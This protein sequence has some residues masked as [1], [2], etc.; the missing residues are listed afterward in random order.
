MSVEIPSAR[1]DNELGN[2]FQR[3]V[4]LL[5]HQ[6]GLAVIWRDQAAH[7][8]L[9]AARRSHSQFST[10]TRWNDRRCT[11]MKCSLCLQWQLSHSGTG[12]SMKEGE[13]MEIESIGQENQRQ[14]GE[15]FDGPGGVMVQPLTA[16]SSYGNHKASPLIFT[17]PITGTKHGQSG[18]KPA[19]WTQAYLAFSWIL[20]LVEGNCEHW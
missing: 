11:N 18:R 9:S 12:E 7:R 15:G 13:L 8:T 6:S 3:Q 5:T 20:H 4:E 19:E 14:P 1:S 2:L 17:A 10:A 16:S